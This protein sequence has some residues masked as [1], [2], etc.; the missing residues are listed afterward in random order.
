MSGINWK[1]IFNRYDKLIDRVGT[2]S[3]FSD[4]VWEMQGELGTSHAYEFGGDYRPTRPY[5]LGCLGADFKLHSKGY[6][7]IN[8]IKGD[9][10][11]DSFKPP[12]LRPGLKIKKGMVITHINA[13]KLSKKY[14]PNHAL[15]NKS[16]TEVVL[17]VLNLKTNK[18]ESVNVQTIASEQALRYRDWVEA[19]RNY[20][21][22]KT[23]NKVGYIHIPDMGPQGFAEFHRYFLTELDY[24]GLV[25]DVR[26][27]GGG[28]VSPL[29][30][31]KLARKR[32]GYDLTRWMGEEPYP[33]E[34]VAGPMIALTNENAG[35]D[36]DIFSH[37][38]K[39]MGLG[40]LIGRR[41]W[42]G[43][44]GIWPRNALVDGTL[45]TQPEFSFWFKD[46]GWSVENYGT[47]V[48]LEVNNLP[49]EYR[50]NIDTQLDKAIDLV[51]KEVKKAKLVK[52]DFKNK[53]NLKLPN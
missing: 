9:T 1:K 32:I 53:P 30:L 34:S 29:I 2:K 14:S 37:S 24:D 17:K 22:K 42:G 27:N 51:Q 26:F 40:K 47:D 10:W 11:T 46:V 38:F 12:L 18:S 16:S 13:R 23:K 52:P 50:K 41:T 3:E 5:R 33:G 45:T 48:D 39:L 6:E 21:H 44:I 15:V 31:S 49:K 20:V 4:L 7:I 8:I 19:N 25:I 43:V 36:G 35:S 28:H